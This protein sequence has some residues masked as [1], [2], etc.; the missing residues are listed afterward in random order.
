MSS[1]PHEWKVQGNLQE[2]CVIVG[3]MEKVLF[4]KKNLWL[5]Q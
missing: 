2:A 1:V 5:T 3:K 4:I